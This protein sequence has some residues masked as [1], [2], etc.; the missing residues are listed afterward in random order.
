M[1]SWRDTLAVDPVPTLLSAGSEA[2][3]YFTRRDLLDE[4]VPPVTR[5]LELPQVEKLLRKQKED[6]R[7]EYPNPKD[8]VRSVEGYDQIE[9]YRILGR[10][11]EMYGL[12]LDHPSA[13]IAADFLLSFQMDA[14][15]IR[16]IYGNQYTPNYTGGILELLTKAGYG[17]DSRVRRGF[18]WLL[19]ARQND[20]GWAIPLLTAGRKLDIEAVHSDTVEPDCSRPFSHMVTGVVLRAFAANGEYRGSPEVRKAAGLLASRLFKRD[21]YRGRDTPD[22]WTKFTF[23]FWF[24]DLLSALDSLSLLGYGY[25]DPNVGEALEWLAGRQRDDG[26]FD[27][28]ILKGKDPHSPHWIC[29]AVCRVMKRCAD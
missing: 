18:D 21:S 2:I 7:W 27:V 8:Y 17:S 14:G 11:V 10:L 3:E 22:F 4:S 29:L 15:D 9:T 20:G 28:K 16:G 1:S 13:R 26:L 24:T 23:P 5:L 12:N 25:A 19:S 6:G